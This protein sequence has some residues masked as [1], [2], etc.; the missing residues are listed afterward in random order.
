LDHGVAHARLGWWQEECERL[1]AALPRHPATVALLRA[2][3]RD[4]TLPPDLL[5]LVAAAR[6]DLAN[7]VPA[8]DAELA[9]RCEHWAS[10]LFRFVPSRTNSSDLEAWLVE[11]GRLLEELALLC[12]LRDD[13]R[14]GRLRL[15]LDALR[16][17][18]LPVAALS[19]DRYPPSLSAYVATRHGR[20]RA[21]L[22][23]RLR[24]LEPALRPSLKTVFVWAE[25]AAV[26]SDRTLRA[27][28]A[29]EPGARLDPLRDAWTAWR[30]ARRALRR[31]SPHITAAPP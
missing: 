8:D 14:A 31:Q 26:R 30:A 7:A 5:P 22:A 27:L 21:S 13:A 28:P 29:R 9:R 6:W 18:E 20:I 2:A 24:T 15:P 3:R 12:A 25:L 19:M 23:E 1:T 16:S 17:L 11:S 10:G 4:R